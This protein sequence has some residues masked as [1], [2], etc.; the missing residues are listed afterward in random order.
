MYLACQNPLSVYDVLL[1]FKCSKWWSSGHYTSLH[2]NCEYSQ[3]WFVNR[4][5]SESKK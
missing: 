5:C 3:T 4:H 2:V 1:I